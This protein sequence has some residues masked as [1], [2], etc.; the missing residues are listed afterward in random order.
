[1]QLTQV[2]E[3]E[4]S[5]GERRVLLCA[6]A[7]DSEALALRGVLMTVEGVVVLDFA[8]GANRAVSVHRSLPGLDAASLA[9]AMDGDLRLA[10][11]PPQ[12]R[13]V[14]AGRTAAGLP[15]C[16]YAGVEGTVVDVA[17][18][19]PDEWRLTEYDG[20]RRTRKTVRLREWTPHGLPGRI[21]IAASGHPRYT[22]RIRLVDAEAAPE[23]K[24]PPP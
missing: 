5:S 23:G 18:P 8:S 21:E 1:M 7:L 3:A 22:L 6:L 13:R 11:F 16:R 12:G 20:W 15:V 2:V 9:R 4:W 19:D 10:F 24:G 14:A 17:R